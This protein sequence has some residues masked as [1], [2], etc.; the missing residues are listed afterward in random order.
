MRLDDDIDEMGG[1]G[2]RLGGL[3]R[4]IRGLLGELDD[5]G[6][7]TRGSLQR[8]D[9]NRLAGQTG[10]HANDGLGKR[11]RIHSGI[12]RRLRPT[13]VFYH[14]TTQRSTPAADPLAVAARLG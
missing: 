12:S 3:G 11:N 9:R 1:G 4:L 14:E 7:D 5:A 8:L 10:L 13:P 2:G 6:V